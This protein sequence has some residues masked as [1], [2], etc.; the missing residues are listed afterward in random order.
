MRISQVRKS[1]EVRATHNTWWRQC[2]LG[3]CKSQ[4]CSQPWSCW[5]V[6]L[7]SLGLLST[8]T[9]SGWMEWGV[10]RCCLRTSWEEDCFWPNCCDQVSKY[11]SDTERGSD[12]GEGIETGCELLVVWPS[13]GSL[14]Y[15]VTQDS[16]VW[17]YITSLLMCTYSVLHNQLG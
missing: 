3:R 2:S 7:V 10:A 6:G 11:G 8:C 1:D 5:S 17:I 14:F 9:C 16:I 13:T 12:D 4:F 15:G